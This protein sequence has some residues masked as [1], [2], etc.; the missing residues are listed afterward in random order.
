MKISTKTGDRGE[1]RLMNGRMIKKSSMV[2]E[3][4]GDLDEFDATLGLCKSI[5][6]NEEFLPIL[7]I[8]QKDIYRIMAIVGNDMRIPKGIKEV[9]R[10][11]VLLLEQYIEKLEEEIGEIRE[12]VMPGKNLLSAN[13]HFARTVC[14]RAERKLV[15]Y[16]EEMLVALGGVPEFI[17]QYINRV[18]DLLFLLSKRA[19]M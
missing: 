18:S 12:F 14:R 10:K 4:L 11:D 3:V 6:L 2:F 15:A 1:S 19:E 17:L 13:L 5:Y 7:E 16:H 8:L 9:D